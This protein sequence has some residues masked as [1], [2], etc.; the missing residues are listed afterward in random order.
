V[1]ADEL[2]A[3][4]L[5]LAS[6]IE[7]LREGCGD[8]DALVDAGVHCL[9]SG[10]AETAAAF[11]RAAHFLDPA[12]VAPTRLLGHALVA[13]HDAAR[14]IEWLEPSLTA[15]PTRHEAAL[16]SAPLNESETRIALAQALCAR[17]RTNDAIA[18]LER[19]VKLEPASGRVLAYLGDALAQAKRYPEALNALNRAVALEPDYGRAYTSL[20]EALIAVGRASSALKPLARALELDTGRGAPAVACGQ[21]LVRMGKLGEA[22][23]W[24]NRAI[25][26][27]P[28]CA[29]AFRHLG[30][31]LSALRLDKE[32][33]DCIRA[34]RQLRNDDW[35]ETWMDEAGLLLRR[36][37][38]RAG[39][40]AYER[41]E[42]AQRLSTVVPPIW[43]G[44]DSIEGESL[45]LIA[46]Q[47]FGDTFQFVRFAPRVAAL[48]AKVTV[49]V[50]APLR[51]LL[52]RCFEGSG[53][54]IIGRGDPRPEFTRQNSLVGMPFALRADG[55]TYSQGV[56]Y[57]FADSTRIPYWQE[58]LSAHASEAGLKPRLRIGVVA[59]GN[60]LFRNDADRSVP[61]IELAPLFAR[62][63]V[64]WVVVQPELRDRDRAT[65]A[66]HASVW[67]TGNALRDFDDTA[68]LLA[69]LDLVISVDTGVAHLAG[70]M[71][72]PVWIMLPFFGD[73]R[74]MHDRNDSPWYP[75]ARLFR[76]PQPQD[77]SSIVTEVQT[78]L[79]AFVPSSLAV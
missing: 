54:E 6:G 47:G 1:A 3:D 44:D 18:E 14:A 77:W 34:A 22:L 27:E 74:W 12:R 10:D 39:W 60:P 16:E 23:Q 66:A 51:N 2:T 41:R 65:L 32:A 25:D 53:V 11:A 73:W 29:E 38:F 9:R 8:I 71:G 70:T 72:R 30:R 79:D 4:E 26:I 68:A 20:G 43:N 33:L 36:G 58:R 15:T 19:A 37:D 28:T 59:S 49:E 48:G 64:Q 50:Q 57:V 24:F 46:E 67:W 61:M 5:T 45:L 40:R 78:A 52:K 35:P 69:S 62:D 17:S 76:Q 75:S 31:T 55:E 13:S 63:D 7:A 42:V 56:P 21:A